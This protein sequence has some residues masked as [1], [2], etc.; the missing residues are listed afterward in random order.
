MAKQSSGT[1][2]P[3]WLT[4]LGAALKERSFVNVCGLDTHVNT[5]SVHITQ[6]NCRDP[7]ETIESMFELINY[8]RGK[9]I[10]MYQ[11]CITYIHTFF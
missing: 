3:F 1:K 5:V 2:D 8:L 6:I 7:K 4:L 11:I 9:N 10:Y